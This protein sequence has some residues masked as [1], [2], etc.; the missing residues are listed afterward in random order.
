[1]FD[2]S[3]QEF[4]G[5]WIPDG[6]QVRKIRRP[7]KNVPTWANSDKKLKMR[8]FGPAM[9]RYRIAYLYWRVGMSAREVSEEVGG[10]LDSINN[11]IKYLKRN[12]DK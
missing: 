11:V 6:F 4:K 9:R 5:N 3:S 1:V 8:I 2:E 7:R 12:G 10:S